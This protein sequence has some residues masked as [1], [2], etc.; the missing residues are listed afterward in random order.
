MIRVAFLGGAFDFPDGARLTGITDPHRDVG[1]HPRGL[2]TAHLVRVAEDQHSVTEERF[3]LAHLPLGLIG[4]HGF[5]PDGSGWFVT[6][7]AL[8]PAAGREVYG[9]HVDAVEVLE[10]SFRRAL[11]GNP[12]A[13]LIEDF[14]LTSGDLRD[15][16]AAKGVSPAHVSAWTTGDLVRGL[17]AELCGT[18]LRSVA[19]G[20][21]AGCA[22][23]SVRHDCRG[24][25]FSDVFGQWEVRGR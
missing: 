21:A 16:Y 2:I 14:A 1:T 9:E 10:A 7:Q 22:F 25:V 4:F 24:D 15:A 12:R 8:D 13:T 3:T 6:F 19:Q 11:R 20:Y 23:P 5:D 17:V 18:T